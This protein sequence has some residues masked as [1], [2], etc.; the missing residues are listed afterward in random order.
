M[1]ICI[2]AKHWLILVEQKT[3]Q[4]VEY[5]R[6]EDLYDRVSAKARNE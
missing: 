4:P 3:D 6:S 5:Y 1:L 2:Y